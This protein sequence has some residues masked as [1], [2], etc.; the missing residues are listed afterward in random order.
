MLHSLLTI[1]DPEQG[2]GQTG[3]PPRWDQGEVLAPRDI[4]CKTPLWGWGFTADASQE[5]HTHMVLI[6]D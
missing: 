6:S 4:S 2:T 3:P 5:I 1:P